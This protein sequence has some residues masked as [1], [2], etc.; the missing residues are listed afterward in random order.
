M[1]E[2]RISGLAQKAGPSSS[3][4][5]DRIV[6]FVSAIIFKSSFDYICMRFLSVSDYYDLHFSGAKY[7]IGWMVILVFLV[8]VSRS[9]RGMLFSQKVV[10]LLF[11]LFFIPMMSLYGLMDLPSVYVSLVIAY[12]IFILVFEEAIPQFK[13]K[14]IKALSVSRNALLLF[15]I[16]ITVILFA[17]TYLYNGFR[18]SLNLLKTY[19]VREIAATAGIP[20]SIGVLRYFA[21]GYL[22]PLLISYLFYRKKFVL[23]LG[24][25]FMELCMF[26]IAMDKAFLF[27]IPVSFASA[28]LVKRL[29]FESH[30]K[31]LLSLSMVFVNVLALMEQVLFKTVFMIVFIV[32]R[33]FLDPAVMNYFYYTVMSSRQKMYLTDSLLLHRFFN[34]K[35]VVTLIADR[36]FQSSLASP[37]TGMF[38][39]AYTEFGALGAVILPLVL[40][41]TLKFVDS[42]S[43]DV[44]PAMMLT[45]LVAMALYLQN[46]FITGGTFFYGY[47]LLL[48]F[49]YL[50]PRTE[51]NLRE[52]N[53]KAR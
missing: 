23:L 46:V 26:S 2:R 28:V 18:I 1:N 30:P 29:K 34:P 16:L 25:V 22:Y 45:C 38:A 5:R 33:T 39:E 21:G 13:V 12:W 52:S 43:V 9:Q 14:R 10:F 31:V 7:V 50:F 17:Y 49:I 27:L 3:S 36:F 11:F 44:E 41:V 6:V 40:I 35:P 8:Y 20:L 37:N 32:R 4:T 24:A 42:V 53:R 47:I 51:R 19:E 48:L 15:I